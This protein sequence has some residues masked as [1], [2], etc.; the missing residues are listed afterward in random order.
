MKTSIIAIFCTEPKSVLYGQASMVPHHCTK[1][2]ENQA[3]HFWEITPDEWMEGSTDGQTL[4]I[5]SSLSLVRTGASE[6]MEAR[7]D[8]RTDTTRLRPTAR[9]GDDNTTYWLHTAGWGQD[10]HKQK[11]STPAWL[12]RS[13]PTCITCM[14]PGACPGLTAASLIP[15]GGVMMRA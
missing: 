10:K 8:G 14:L 11:A 1:F 9:W 4:L 7:M 6:E 5:L 2:E 3:R 15:G 13:L 12:H